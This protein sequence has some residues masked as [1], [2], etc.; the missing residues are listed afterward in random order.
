NLLH[1]RPVLGLHRDAL[2]CQ[3]CSLLGLGKGVLPAQPGVQ[4]AEDAPLAHQVWPSPLHQIVL[5]GWAVLV[6]CSSS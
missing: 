2:K 3:C 1:V 6:Q 4:D 5:P